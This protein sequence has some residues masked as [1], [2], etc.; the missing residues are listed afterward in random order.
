MYFA[1][2]VLRTLFISCYLPFGRYLLYVIWLRRYVLRVICATHVIFITPVG[3]ININNAKKITFKKKI[4][5][6]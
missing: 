1:L 5:F 4:S 6:L 3:Q 2:F